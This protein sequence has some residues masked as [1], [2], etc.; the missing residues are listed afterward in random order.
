M[1]RRTK[2]ARGEKRSADR[3]CLGFLIGARRS[4]GNAALK[5]RG[6]NTVIV[7]GLQV[8]SAAVCGWISCRW[9]RRRRG[10]GALHLD[11]LLHY[12][13]LLNRR[14]NHWLRL[15]DWFPLHLLQLH[16]L[17]WSRMCECTVA[18]QRHCS[19]DRLLIAPQSPRPRASWQPEREG[20]P[21]LAVHA[22][23]PGA[24][25]PARPDMRFQSAYRWRAC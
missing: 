20:V 8:I 12:H 4:C 13:R 22:A 11:R 9:F 15:H 7:P 18:G 19:G 10:R 1:D 16:L 25:T 21:L 6:V 14:H 17:L 24:G 3:K 23:Y 5:L 2:T